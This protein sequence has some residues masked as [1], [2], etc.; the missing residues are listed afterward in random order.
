[1]HPQDMWLHTGGNLALNY[2]YLDHRAHMGHW[3]TDSTRYFAD[4]SLDEAHPTSDIL[5]GLA[6]LRMLL[7]MG[8]TS[9]TGGH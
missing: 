2:S 6:W 1:M 3:R 4:C 8:E 9:R 7:A 5:D